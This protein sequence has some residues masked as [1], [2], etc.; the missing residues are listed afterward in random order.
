MGRERSAYMKRLMDL[1]ISIL[2]LGIFLPFIL[3]IAVLVKLKL[4]SPVF[5][6]QQRPGLNEKT[7]YLYKFRSMNDQRD[8]KGKLLPDYQRLNS[9]GIFIR[10][11]SLDEIPQLINVIMGEISLVGPRPLLMEY[12]P[13]YSKEQAKRHLVKPGITGWA[14]VNGRNAITWEEKF[15]YDVWYVNHHSIILDIKILW[16]TLIKVFRSEG[17][18]Q[19]ENLTMTPFEGTKKFENE[20]QG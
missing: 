19:A 4:G 2:L 16:L 15:K 6:K 5:L 12:L 3:L 20:I 18:N 17:I 10:K 8:S 9:F 1:I 14:Q 7:F 13:L 11:Y